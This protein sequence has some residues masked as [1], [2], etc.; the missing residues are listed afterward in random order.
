MYCIICIIFTFWGKG[1]SCSSL[2]FLSLPQKGPAE[3][4]L[5]LKKQLSLSCCVCL[6]YLRL[7]REL[8]KTWNSDLLTGVYSI[9]SRA[10]PW[11]PSFCANFAHTRDRRWPTYV[12]VVYLCMAQSHSCT[13]QGKQASEDQKVV[14]LPS[15][16]LRQCEQLFHLDFSFGCA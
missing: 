16:A 10:E 11:M 6:F 4:L 9:V 5:F 12:C 14:C 8:W 2:K 3:I 7:Q 1:K 15:Q 13:H